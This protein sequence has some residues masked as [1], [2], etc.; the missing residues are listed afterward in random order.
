LIP[1]FAAS[2]WTNGKALVLDD[3]YDHEVWNRTEETR[4][5][6]LVVDIWHP[7]ISNAEKQEIVKVF[8]EAQQQGLW[9]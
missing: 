2:P 9:K 3:S 5:L 8:Q 7:D 6:L 4:I 1:P